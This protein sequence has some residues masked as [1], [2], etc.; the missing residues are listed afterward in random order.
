MKSVIS[1]HV[2][3]FRKTRNLTHLGK[4][5]L[6]IVS[7]G[8]FLEL[9]YGIYCNVLFKPSTV[10][11]SPYSKDLQSVIHAAL[12]FSSSDWIFSRK[13]LV[14]IFRT[15]YAIHLLPSDFCGTRSESIICDKDFLIIGEYGVPEGKRLVYVTQQSCIIYDHYR[16]NRHIAHIHAL[17][18]S[19]SSCDILVT[20][21]DSEKRL[22]LW[23]LKADELVYEK[24]LRRSLAGHTAITKVGSMYYMGTDFS[25]RPNYIERLSDGKKFF[26]PY[27]AYK[28]WVVAFQEHQNRYIVSISTELSLLGGKKAL[29]VF[30]TA[31]E[32]FVYCD[33]IGEHTANKALH[34]T[35]IP[36]RSIAAGE[37]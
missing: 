18:K 20:T 13:Q 22:D 6:L 3:E 33:Y 26:F 5:V 30:D 7:Q 28:M 11:L 17:H 35:A 24:T 25:S 14:D 23:R 9:I 32:E 19:A 16:P 8:R 10:A 21:G 34:R 1:Y 31:T 12:S 2:R 37:L 4:A 15:H 36:L 27:P 29:S